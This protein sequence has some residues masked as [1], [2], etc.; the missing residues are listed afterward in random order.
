MAPPALR[1][2]R[3]YWKVAW[4]ILS[5]RPADV[6]YAQSI[7]LRIGPKTPRTTTWLPSFPT[8][9]PFQVDFWYPHAEAPPPPQRTA[10]HSPCGISSHCPLAFRLATL[11]TFS[12]T[13]KGAGRKG[14]FYNQIIFV[15]SSA[16]MLMH[17]EA[18]QMVQSQLRWC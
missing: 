18:R 5:F 7:A 8:N 14:A 15:H 10:C 11:L 1:I 9:G 6:P 2:S 16:I 4:P 3:S 13:V 17:G 12:C